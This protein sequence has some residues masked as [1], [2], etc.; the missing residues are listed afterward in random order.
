MK[1]LLIILFFSLKSFSQ[2]SVRLKITFSK[3]IGDTVYYEFKILET[4][5]KVFSKCCC[6]QHKKGEVIKV[7]KEFIKSEL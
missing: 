6:K 5:E 4:K 2:D 7:S 1:F 3:K